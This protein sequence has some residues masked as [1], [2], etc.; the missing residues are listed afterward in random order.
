MLDAAAHVAE[1]DQAWLAVECVATHA[2]VSQ[3][4]VYRHSGSRAGLIEALGREC[5]MT[6]GP[7]MVDARRRILEAAIAYPAGRRQTYRDRDQLLGSGAG[8]RICTE[9]LL[10]T[11]REDSCVPIRRPPGIATT[12]YGR[13]G[14]EISLPP[15]SPRPRRE[16]ADRLLGRRGIL[17]TSSV[18]VVGTGPVGPIEAVVASASRAE[19]IAPSVPVRDPFR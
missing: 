4:T 11:N 13:T 2:A 10:F 8:T 19:T 16:L 5:G 12:D 3:A 9:D 6:G 18:A 14:V 7:G 17:A 15:M 1:S